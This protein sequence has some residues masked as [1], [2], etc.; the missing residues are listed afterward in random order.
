MFKEKIARHFGLYGK[1]ILVFGAEA[2]V[3]L[4]IILPWMFKPGYLFFTD[5]AWGPNVLIKWQDNWFF[6][7]LIVKGASYIIPIDF[8]QKVF[9]GLILF[10][11]LLGSYKLIEEIILFKKKTECMS[12]RG[13]IFILSLFAL[14]NPFI[15]DRVM[16]GQFNIVAA[17]GLFCLALASLLAYFRNNEFKNFIGFGIFSGLMVLFSMHF[18]FFS[19]PLMFLLAVLAIIKKQINWKQFL[20]GVGLVLVFVIIINLNWLLGLASQTPNVLTTIAAGISGQDLSAFQTSGKTGGEVI[21][22]VLMM[23][24]FWG[25]DQHRYADLT[26]F[27]TNWGRSF[28][29]LLPLILYGV[30]RGFKSEDKKIKWL[31]GGL[32]IIFCIAAFLAVG[33]RTGLTKA[34]TLWLFDNLP[35]YKG[36]RETQKWV[37]VEVVVYL[38]FLSWGAK[39][40]FQKTIIARQQSVFKIFLAA[41]IIMQAPLLLWGFGGQIRP[42]SYPMDWYE[43]DKLIT[44]DSQCQ[45]KILFLPWHAYMSFGWIG[46]IVSN[47]ASVFFTCPVVVGTNMEWGGIYD[48]SQNPTGE[49]VINWVNSNGRT[50][51]LLDKKLNIKYVVLAK[52]LDWAAYWNLFRNNAELKLISDTATLRIYKV[53]E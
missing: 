33:V 10:V 15:Y 52:E 11:V 27:D 32:L 53:N 18:V 21:S 1:G 23:S 25:K 7:N 34:V 24:G 43:A 40:F 46:S 17:F 51:L 37:A 20:K 30:Y 39:E 42:I 38:I 16:Y 19:F 22:N 13:L 44:K 5:F 48:N 36:L 14:F 28:L 47:P 29:L 6:L 8:L 4:A 9:I 31:T 12:N 50:D 3:V 26:S 45:G 2:V 41:I 49:R 35:F